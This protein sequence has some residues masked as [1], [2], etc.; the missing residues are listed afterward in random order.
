MRNDCL[1]E[2]LRV[3]RTHGAER[4]RV[5]DN[6]PEVGITLA[7]LGDDLFGRRTG[8]GPGEKHNFPLTSMGGGQRFQHMLVDLIP[9]GRLSMPKRSAQPFVVIK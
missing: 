2:R 1:A 9:L 5:I 4:D 6:V 7:P 8:D 3:G